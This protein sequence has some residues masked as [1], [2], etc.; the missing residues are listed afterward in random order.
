MKM[1]NFNY[2][3]FAFVMIIAFYDSS[4]KSSKYIENNKLKNDT[5]NNYGK[6]EKYY[7]KNINYQE[8]DTNYQDSIKVGYWR[9]VENINTGEYSIGKY[10]NKVFIMDPNNFWETDNIYGKHTFNQ[11]NKIKLYPRMGKW[12]FFDI[13]D[14]YLCSKYYY[15]D[16]CLF[17]SDLNDFFWRKRENIEMCY[18]KKQKNLTLYQVDWYICPLSASK[19]DLR[20]ENLYSQVFLDTTNYESAY[21]VKKIYIF[22]TVNIIDSLVFDK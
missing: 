11:V 15:N 12:N 2:L 9:V 6:G 4:L 1:K 5:L 8:L 14:K 17:V 20:K 3:T 7:Y 22:N 13:N 10:H 16:K 18:V 21:S 19:S